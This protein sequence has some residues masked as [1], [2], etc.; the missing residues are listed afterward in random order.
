MAT[1][2]CKLVCSLDTL[3]ECSM[4]SLHCVNKLNDMLEESCEEDLE[5]IALGEQLEE[6][7]K[8]LRKG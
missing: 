7:F 8:A 5:G 1:A 6:I 4:I 2:T 3:P